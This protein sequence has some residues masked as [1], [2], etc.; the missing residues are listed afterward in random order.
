MPEV[1]RWSSAPQPAVAI[2]QIAEALR[3][4]NLLALPTETCYVVAARAAVPDAVAGLRRIKSLEPGQP[5]TVVVRSVLEASQWV[6]PFSTTGSRLAR[7]CWPGP[8]TLIFERSREQ[9]PLSNLPRAVQEA[10]APGETV[11]L[12]ISA[13]PVL[14]SVVRELGEP[15]V[16]GSVRDSSGV[17]VTTADGASL[18]LGESV[19]LICDGGASPWPNHSTVVQMQGEKHEVLREG[20]LTR[21]DIALLTNRVIVFV[22][23]GNTCRSPM[24]ESLC[25]RLLAR[26]LDCN[27][28]ELPARGFLVLS[29]GMAAMMGEQA[30]P[31]AMEAAAELGADLGRHASRPLTPRLVAQA[32]DL[33]VMTHGH[34]QTIGQLYPNSAPALR[35]LSPNGEDVVDPFSGDLDCYRACAASI[36][37]HLERLMTELA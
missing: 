13:H 35:L 33:I 29:A 15:I 25:K 7:R 23:T 21:A 6:M 28:Q 26:K 37:S 9:S 2:R 5:S 32:D 10:I 16:I 20:V 1:L 4:G 34:A 14:D 30:S 12:R 27:I 24:A 17:V 31:G 19:D 8:A 3:R 22:C 11:A 18:A 36:Q